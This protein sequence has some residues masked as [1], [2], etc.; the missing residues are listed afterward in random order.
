MTF[1]HMKT[2]MHDDTYWF[3]YSG[4]GGCAIVCVHILYV[5][6]YAEKYDYVHYHEFNQEDWLFTYSQRLMYF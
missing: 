6:S 5:A 4:E 2:Q 1:V 3:I